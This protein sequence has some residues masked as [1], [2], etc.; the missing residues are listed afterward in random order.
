MPS[1]IPMPVRR[2]IFQRYRKGVSVSKLAEELELSERT[3]RHLVR[4]FASRGQSALAPDYARCA[5]KTAATAKA[6]YHRAVDMRR[7]HPS[8]GAGLIRVL[9]QEELAACPSE[10]TLQRWFRQA[11]LS[12]APPGRHSARDDYRARR[13]HEVWQMDAAERILLA[14][15]ERV[16]WL[17]LVDE[18]SGAVVQTTI[19][20]PGLLG[21]GGSRCRSRRLASGFFQVGT[22]AALSGRQRHALGI[23]R[24]FAYGPGSVVDRLGRGHAVESAAATSRQRRGRTLARHGQALGRAEYLCWPTRIATAAR[25]DGPD[26]T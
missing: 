6:M 2:A 7:Q 11:G 26:S 25:R 19:F 10:R 23:E 5:T 12:P 17:R 8:W 14:S 20:P 18:C 22:A 15:G 21:F 24:R 4:R 3:V 13:P 9:L 16:S 1:P